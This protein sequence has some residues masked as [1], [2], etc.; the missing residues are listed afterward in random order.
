MTPLNAIIPTAV[1]VADWASM[2]FKTVR[3]L[4]NTAADIYNA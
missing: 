3:N 2:P 4:Y 1:G